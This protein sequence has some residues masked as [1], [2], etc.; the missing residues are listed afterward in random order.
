MRKNIDIKIRNKKYNEKQI[1]SS[2]DFEDIKVLNNI[3]YIV[4]K[5]NNYDLSIL[6]QLMDNTFSKIKNGLIFIVNV[7]DNNVNYLCRS[8]CSLEAGA[9]VKEAS[10]KSNGNGGGSKNFA[11]GGGTTAEFVEDILS[12]IEK[13]IGE[14]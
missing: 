6:K 14:L 13:K 10:M 11:Q 8:N 3:D 9:L 5:V 4:K 12:D 1:N 7:K 2:K